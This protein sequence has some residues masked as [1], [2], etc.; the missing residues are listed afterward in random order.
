MCEALQRYY[1]G[2]LTTG[3]VWAVAERVSA[4]AARAYQSIARQDGSG[5]GR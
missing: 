3:D 2:E 1:D 5:R 4:H